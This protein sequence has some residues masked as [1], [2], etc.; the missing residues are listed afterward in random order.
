MEHVKSQRLIRGAGV[1]RFN[2]PKKSTPHFGRVGYGAFPAVSFKDLP[3]EKKSASRGFTSEI[4][5][6]LVFALIGFYVAI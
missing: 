2:R 3:K 6:F 5:I 1:N 4:E